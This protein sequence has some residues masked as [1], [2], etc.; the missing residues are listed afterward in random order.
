[1]QIKSLLVLF[2]FAVAIVGVFVVTGCCS[3][4]LPDPAP[5]PAEKAGAALDDAMKK[6]GE[7]ARKLADKANEGIKDATS[8]A[9]DKAGDVLQKAG[10]A[11]EKT[12]ADLQDKSGN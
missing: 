10:A 6:T 9:A 5:G 8:K 11:I 7:E 12:G 2:F 1:M 4:T 3:K